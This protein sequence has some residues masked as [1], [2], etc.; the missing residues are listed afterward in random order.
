MD[1]EIFLSIPQIKLERS[2]SP[3]EVDTYFRQGSP[4]NLHANVRETLTGINREME[5]IQSR[6]VHSSTR[7]DQVPENSWIDE[8]LDF[9]SIVSRQTQS[10]LNRIKCDFKRSGMKF[11][12][13]FRNHFLY[14]ANNR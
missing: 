2:E 3:I 11:D 5:S 7:R 4:V 14:I 12:A 6:N 9:S 1:S 8:L 13:D 10:C